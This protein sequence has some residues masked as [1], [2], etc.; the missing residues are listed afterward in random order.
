VLGSFTDEATSISVYKRSWLPLEQAAAL[1]ADSTGSS[2]NGNK[3]S[4]KE[5]GVAAV[6]EA[7][8][9]AFLAEQGPP[10]LGK[11][12]HDASSKQYGM[13]TYVGGQL[14]ARFR[15][16]FEC[17]INDDS[18]S[19]ACESS[20]TLAIDNVLL[21]PGDTVC[22]GVSS[23]NKKDVVVENH[24]QKLFDFAQTYFAAKREDQSNMQCS[25]S[26]V[27][28]PRKDVQAVEPSGQALS[29]SLVHRGDKLMNPPTPKQRRTL[30]EL[31]RSQEVDEQPLLQAVKET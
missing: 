15:A 17:A 8:L 28:Q 3:R 19:T 7:F 25:K 30:P 27:E 6:L 26:K 31:P 29:T 13:P 5:G 24:L 1:A 21:A 10:K 18:A 12:T 2:T 4:T 9:E 11:T 22:D 20:T 14:Y 23:G 16:W